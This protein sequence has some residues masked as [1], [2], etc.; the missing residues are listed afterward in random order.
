MPWGLNRRFLQCV[1]VV[2]NIV[3][4]ATPEMGCTAAG[5]DGRQCGG[6]GGL[7]VA[8]LNGLL[9]QCMPTPTSAEEPFIGAAAAAGLN[10]TGAPTGTPVFYRLG[11]MVHF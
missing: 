1:D 9:R 10:V 2:N 7:R 11:C 8:G 4:A 3:I 5:E 6:P